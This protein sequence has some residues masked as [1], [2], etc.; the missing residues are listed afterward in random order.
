MNK[1]VAL[2][3]MPGSGKSIV[4]DFFKESGFS[5]IRFGQITLDIVKERGLQP[6]EDNEKIVREEVRKNHGMGAYAK[7]NIPKIKGL[8]EKGNVV[9][10]G[11]YSWS[12]Y[13]VL[14][15]EFGELL[16]VICVYAPPTLRYKR[17]SER[18]LEASDKILRNRPF[19]PEDARR[20]DYNE[21]ENIEKG[22]PIAMA[23]YILINTRSVEELKKQI[24]NLLKELK[25]HHGP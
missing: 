5:Y 19:S 3:G 8:I 6:T 21:I 9:V 23:D 1:I 13:K 12:E 11:L 10:D 7:L 25:P 17:L 24:E 16:I 2:V 18:K 4:G 15:D 20:R 14:K 22:G